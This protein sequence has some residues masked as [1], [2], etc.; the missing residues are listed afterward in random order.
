MEITNEYT[1]FII[2]LKISSAQQ[3]L[4]NTHIPNN[5]GTLFVWDNFIVVD[6]VIVCALLWSYTPARRK[7]IEILKY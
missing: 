3:T 1:T 4:T 6:I 2:K 5:F 7:E